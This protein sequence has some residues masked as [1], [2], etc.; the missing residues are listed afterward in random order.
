VKAMKT[1]DIFHIINKF[2]IFDCL[3]GPHFLLGGWLAGS[4]ITKD[5][6]PVK[7]AMNSLAMQR[8]A[9]VWRGTHTFAADD[10][11]LYWLLL[12][13]CIFEYCT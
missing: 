8:N 12:N 9:I 2:K 13:E 4:P 1:T 5:Y 6:V 10:P 3:F 11:I 7:S